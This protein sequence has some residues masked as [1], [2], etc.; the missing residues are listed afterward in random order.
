M[1]LRFLEG[2]EKDRILSLADEAVSFGRGR[3]NDIVLNEEGISRKHGRLVKTAEGWEIE[4]LG[5]MNGIRVNGDRIE[6]KRVLRPGDHIAICS[7]LFMLAGDDD[8]GE[9]TPAVQVQPTVPQSAPQPSGPPEGGNAEQQAAP[10][11]WGRIALLAVVVALIAVLAF[12]MMQEPGTAKNTLAE[13][14]VA[15]ENTPLEPDGMEEPATELSDAELAELIAEE[16]KGGN[17]AEPPAN[18]GNAPTADGP[19]QTGE[20]AENPAP[21][22]VEREPTRQPTA[23][24]ARRLSSVVLVASDPPGADVLLDGEGKGISPVILRDLSPGRHMVGIRKTGF[25]PFDRQIHVPDLLPTRPY[26]LRLQ[27]GALR[28]R[29]TPPGAA[30]W[31]G[32]QLLGITPLLKTGIPPGEYEVRLIAPGCEPAKKTISV[33]SIRGESYDIDLVSLLG[34]LELLTEPPGC[35]VVL[36]G[37]GKGKTAADEDGGRSGTLRIDG[38]LPGEHLL[39]VEH[40]CGAS[41]SGKVRIT[42]GE[43]TRLT[44]KLWIPDT[45]VVL[46]DGTLRYGFLVEKTKYGDLVLAERPKRLKRYLKPEIAEMQTLTLA[47]MRDVYKELVKGNA[48]HR[49]GGGGTDNLNNREVQDGGWGD[50]PVPRKEGAENPARGPTVE[51]GTITISEKDLAIMFKQRSDTDINRHFRNRR[52]VVS[53]VPTSS[54]KD[55]MGGYVAFGRRIRCFID[56]DVYLAQKDKIKAA[57]NT[58]SPIRV[59]GTSPGMRGSILVLRKSSMIE[60]GGE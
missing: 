23:P 33:S 11:P 46:N 18:E 42:K 41:R 17:P 35:A 9:N 38:L 25:E 37:L 55:G 24:G 32:K 52:V 12:L 54:G 14:P 10:L 56:R 8:M 49:A 15:G 57:V 16:E 58:E 30:V 51:G 3:D 44:V 6:G 29:T 59:G 39:V 48:E 36:D 26:K 20:P 31:H 53:G 28:I 27:A 50:E 60:D 47:E 22:A 43:R 4:D 7:Q 21:A 45:K 40:P 1:K 2:V 13:Q 34:G 19:P 5:S